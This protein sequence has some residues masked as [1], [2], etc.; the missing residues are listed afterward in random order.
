MEKLVRNNIPAIVARETLKSVGFRVALEGEMEQL[1]INKLIEEFREF[2]GC[3][4]NDK[5]LEE[6]CEEYYDFTE[7]MKLAINYKY[8]CNQPLAYNPAEKYNQKLIYK[9]SFSDRLVMRFDNYPIDYT[10]KYKTLYLRKNVRL[11]KLPENKV[12]L[13]FADGTSTSGYEFELANI[14]IP[15]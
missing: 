5:S 1:I 3:I 2:I 10:K 4:I 12:E 8:N 14:L 6:S 11:H 15:D 9:G 7:V 13:K